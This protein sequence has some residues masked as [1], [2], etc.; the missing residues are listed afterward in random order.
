MRHLLLTGLL[1]ALA[2]LA[3]ADLQDRVI[4]RA[5]PDAAHPDAL[6][7][8]YEELFGEPFPEYRDGPRPLRPMRPFEDVEA[9][10]S[11]YDRATDGVAA[12]VSSQESR[13]VLRVTLPGSEGRP[14]A[15]RTDRRWC[16]LSQPGTA[17]SAHRLIRGKEHRIP[18]P[19]GA[20]PESAAVRREGDVVEISFAAR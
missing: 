17:V 16:V 8:N 14:V 11:A 19:R 9:F 4:D 7:V 20:D 5:F 1:L 2:P 12:S 15:V 3:H 18:L 13:V 10:N 6:H